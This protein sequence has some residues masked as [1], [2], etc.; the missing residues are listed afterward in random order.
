ML[1]VTSRP[2]SR[3]SLSTRRFLMSAVLTEI[4]A[5]SSHPVIRALTGL[6]EILGKD[7]EA[8][9][10][11][12]TGEALLCLYDPGEI[13]EILRPSEDELRRSGA[14][15]YLEGSWWL[16]GRPALRGRSDI[17]ECDARVVRSRHG[18]LTVYQ[19]RGVF[20]LKL[21]RFLRVTLRR[22]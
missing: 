3:N 5:D 7:A 21:Q 4:D 16:S 22:A 15:K 11:N 13:N 9:V 18:R 1:A 6:L 2:N 14:G 20:D 17:F 12:F 10:T 8:L 19:L